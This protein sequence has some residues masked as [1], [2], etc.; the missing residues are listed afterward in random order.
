MKYMNY[1]EAKIPALGLGTWKSSKGDVYGAVREA[2]HIGYTHIDCAPAYE[3][4]EEVGAALK[5]MTDSGQIKRENIWITSKLWNNAH[6]AADVEPALRKTLA[7]LRLDYLDLYLIHWPVAFKPGVSFPR[8]ASD[9]LRPEEA[10]ITETWQA[11]EECV[12]KGLVKHIGVCNFNVRRIGELLATA[13]V[14]PMMNQIEL[15][16]YLQQNDMLEYCRKKN[17]LLT[18]YSPLG[19]ADRPKGMKRKDE[20]ALLEN[21]VIAQIAG[22]HGCTPA[23]V[24]ISWALHRETVVIPKSVNRQRLQE[25]LEAGSITLGS[26]E[27]KKIAELD[28]GFRYVDGAFWESPGSGYTKAGLWDE[29]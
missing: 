29:Q 13:S 12:G 14:P 11:L 25:N 6:L 20:P 5:E 10:P 4:E 15:H 2:L 8:K 16:P 21:E 22:K 3:N 18:A 19:S 23:Q 28:R 9:Y 26:D 17:I 7:D 24:L 1:Q 27:M